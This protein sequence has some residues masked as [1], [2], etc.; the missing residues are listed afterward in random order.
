MTTPGSRILV[1]GAGLAGARC[2]ETLRAGGTRATSCWSATSRWRPTS[3]VPCRRTSSQVSASSTTSSSARTRSGATGDRAAARLSDRVRRQGCG[4]GDHSGRRR[5]VLGH[6]RARDRRGAAAPAVRSTAQ[7]HVLRTGGRR[8][9]APAGARAW[10]QAR[11]RGR[12]LRR[13]RGGL[14]GVQAGR[15]GDDARPRARSLPARARP[16]YRPY[17]GPPLPR[18]RHR[19]PRGQRRHR[20]SHRARRPPQRRGAHRRTGARM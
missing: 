14:D 4:H 16:G 8:A 1:V 5:S 6:A 20:V 3:G 9:R 2:A 12:R 18:P 19:C 15:Q 11:D 7:R 13:G 10:S 17:A